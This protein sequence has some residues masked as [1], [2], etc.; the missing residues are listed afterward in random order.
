MVLIDGWMDGEE[1]EKTWDVFTARM[2]I[3]DMID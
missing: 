3:D 2:H 1:R